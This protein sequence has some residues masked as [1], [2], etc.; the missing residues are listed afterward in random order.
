MEKLKIL[1]IVSLFAVFTFSFSAYGQ[2]VL[3]KGLKSMESSATEEERKQYDEN[4]YRRLI[5]SE[6]FDEY[7]QLEAQRENEHN[8]HK[9]EEHKDKDLIALEENPTES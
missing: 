3:E 7:K 8:Q 1:S 4:F 9:K 2:C 6:A 5:G